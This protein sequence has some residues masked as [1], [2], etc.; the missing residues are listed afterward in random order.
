MIPSSACL[1]WPPDQPGR[2]GIE[3][4]PRSYT[5]IRDTTP[6]KP[7]AVAYVDDWRVITGIFYVLRT[8]LALA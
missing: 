4:A 3:V 8:R 6:N 1:P 2:A 5:S 7:R